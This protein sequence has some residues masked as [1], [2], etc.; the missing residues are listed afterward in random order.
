[1]P[2]STQSPEDDG[3]CGLKVD[4]VRAVNHIAAVT[5][6]TRIPLEIRFIRLLA[7]RLHEY[8]TAAHRLE[9][10]VTSAS[11]RL[12]LHCEIFSTPTSILLAFRDVDDPNS[13]S[14]GTT[15]I[16]LQPGSID[17][18]KLCAVDAIADDVAAGKITLAEGADRLLEVPGTPPVAP[19]AGQLIA[20]GVVG[21]TVASLLGST[22]TDAAIAAAMAM[23]TGLFTLRLGARWKEAGS[24]EPIVA[25]LITVGAYGLAAAFGGGMVPNVVIGALIILMPGLDLTIAITELSTGHLASGTARFAGATVV[26]LKLALGVMLG[27][28]VMLWL[29]FVGD[30]PVDPSQLSPGWFTWLALF[31]TGIAFGPLFNAHLRDWPA[32]VVAAVA[33]YASSYFATQAF[34]SEIGVFLAALTIGALSNLYARLINRPAAVMRMPGI[35]LLVPGSLG[36]RAL[37][38]LFSKN[39]DE[40]IN[41]AI[42]VVVVL[43]VL[44]G[45]L[46]LGNTLISPRRNL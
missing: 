14:Y 3:R 10:A 19:L 27:T 12:G 20:W 21:A 32:V 40:G 44:V 11:L 7:R 15:L 45:G 4:F 13:D 36:Y 9:N 5:R 25:F 34:G 46:L 37:N 6:E 35:I 30:Q 42:S 26:L 17:L 1:M 29:G 24:F 43:A 16:R 28:Q 39:V 41:A 2:G 18:E 31:A 23:L 38:F 22:W 8:G 33:A